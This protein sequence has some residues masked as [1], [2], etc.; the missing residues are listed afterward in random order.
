M[1]GGSARSA[2]AAAEAPIS[3]RLV[4]FLRLLRGSGFNLGM[5]EGLDALRLARGI[6]LA[7]PW[8]LR[9]GLR[10]LL[11]SS[12]ADWRRFDELFDGYWLGRGRRR[13]ARVADAN[14]GPGSAGRGGGGDGRQEGG[15][16][17]VSPVHGSL[18][19][20]RAPPSS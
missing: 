5:G 4:G 2:P 19:R 15:Q 10:A 18:S 9:W 12:E 20:T 7:R 11:C 3:R 17:D 16:D 13:L 6:D 1:S 14:V 8:Q